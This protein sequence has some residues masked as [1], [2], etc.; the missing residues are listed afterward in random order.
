MAKK[1]EKAYKF[2]MGTESA[3]FIQYGYWDNSKQGLVAGEK[4]QL[5][6]RQMEKSYLEDNRRELELSKSISLAQLNPLALIELRETGKCS[7]FLPEELFDLDFPGHYFRRIKAV[8]LSIPCVAGPYTSLS[9]TLRLLNNTVRINTALG[10]QYEPNNEEDDRFRTNYT[11]VTAIATSSAQNDSGTF[12]FNFRDERYLPFELAGAISEWQLE[13]SMDKKLRPFDYSTISDVILHLNYTARESGGTFKDK[14]TEHIYQYLNN[15]SN[16]VEQ[17]LLM[18]MFSAKHE[19][20]TNWSRFLN[21]YQIEKVAGQDQL[22]QTL[23]LDLTQEHFPFLFQGKTITSVQVD[24]F[25]KFKDLFNKNVYKTDGTPLGDFNKLT[26]LLT[27]PGGQESSHSLESNSS[28]PQGI[29]HAVVPVSNNISGTWV[30]KLKE[31]DVKKIA[32]SLQ[33]SV[34]VDQKEHPRLKAEAIEDIL[35]LYHYSVQ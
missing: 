11:P 32:K 12:D 20:P 22:N 27:P 25:L 4:L 29:P 6:L 21:A 31:D 14:A 24:L 9:C 16:L 7:V 8:R 13:L 34:K 18:Q 1:A 30:L 15:A 3:S 10:T 5:A 17:P 19:F 23:E 2:E 28:V 35:I 33:D 26:F